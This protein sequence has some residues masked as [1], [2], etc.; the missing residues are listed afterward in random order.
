MTSLHACTALRYCRV[1]GESEAAGEGVA[2]LQAL[3]L[4]AKEVEKV[5]GKKK[6]D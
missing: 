2:R 3:G 4:Q 5:V 6:D 1:G